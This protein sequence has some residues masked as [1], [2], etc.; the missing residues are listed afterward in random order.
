MLSLGH[1]Q[2]PAPGGFIA[3]GGK[4]KPNLGWERFWLS[5]EVSGALYVGLL[6]RGVLCS[7]LASCLRCGER[8]V[9]AQAF[10]LRLAAFFKIYF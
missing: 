8:H 10:V 6:G 4:K 5:W 9:C 3:Q 1:R 2:H 7:E